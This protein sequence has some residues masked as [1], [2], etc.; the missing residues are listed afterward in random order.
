V[1]NSHVF[2]KDVGR[3]AKNN[4]WRGSD[5]GKP[6]ET[7]QPTIRPAERFRRSGLAIESACVAKRWERKVVVDRYTDR[8]P[9]IDAMNLNAACDS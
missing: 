5:N 8:S 6:T 3:Q 1:Y 7:Q 9:P 4:D 2:G